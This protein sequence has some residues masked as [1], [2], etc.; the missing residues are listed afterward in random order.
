M[1]IRIT[2]LGLGLA[3]CSDSC[4]DSELSFRASSLLY[5]LLRSRRELGV[6]SSLRVRT[7]ESDLEFL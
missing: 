2:G 4:C 5:F 6:L 3:P 1:T 7:K